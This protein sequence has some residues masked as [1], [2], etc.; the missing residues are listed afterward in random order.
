M[1][2]NMQ[3][4]KDPEVKMPVALN[5]SWTYFLGDPLPQSVPDL[6]YLSITG[7]K[8]GTS[9]RTRTHPPLWSTPSPP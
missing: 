9:A 1:V 6:G 7:D 2:L 8:G 3:G 5:Q 4:W